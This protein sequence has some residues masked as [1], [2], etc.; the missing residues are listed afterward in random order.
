MT[1]KLALVVDDSR[2][3][4]LLLRRMLERHEIAVDTAESAEEALEYLRH[5]KPDVIFMDHMMPG[6]DGLEAVRLIKANPATALIPIMM[7]TSKE[8]EVYVGE[9]R[10]LGAV[11]VLPKEV[12]P[13]DLLAVLQGLNLLGEPPQPAAAERPAASVPPPLPRVAAQA[14]AAATPSLAASEIEIIARNAADE[15]LMRILKAQL[16]E[17]RRGLKTDFQSA[18]DNLEQELRPPPRRYAFRH[19]WQSAAIAAVAVLLLPLA[20]YLVGARTPAGPPATVVAPPARPATE[21]GD[22]GLLLRGLAQQ[23]LRTDQEKAVLLQTLE[24]ALN[25][26]GTFGH[27]EIPFDDR[28]LGVI[29]ELA[30]QLT[31]A[32]FRGTIR[33][34]AYHGDFCLI[35]DG[36][37]GLRLAPDDLPLRQCHALGTDSVPV[38]R[39]GAQQ[40][41][42]FANFIRSSPLFV[43]GR[44]N[45]ELNSH[46]RTNPRVEY[47]PVTEPVVAGE[48]NAVARHNQR[49]EI[50]LVPQP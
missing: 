7:Y 36:S 45:V 47:P 31:A 17:H 12:K 20:G 30:Q 38:R 6:M 1:K 37:G 24:W 26:H 46:G 8:G 33:L 14:P 19:R 32:N 50:T 41:V 16:E 28:R 35:Q 22:Q 15:A 13:A 3:A 25:R 48:W 21:A 27:D 9:A 29:S 11:G 23:R 18:L 4:L 5:R 40:S 2:S 10:A 43:Q 34:D 44:L 49:I 42:A 39:G